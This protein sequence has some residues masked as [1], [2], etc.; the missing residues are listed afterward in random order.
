MQSSSRLKSAFSSL[1]GTSR[2]LLLIAIV[3]ATVFL[4]QLGSARLWD[5]DEPRNAGC[6]AEMLARNDWVT[7]MFNDELR[8]Q[9]PVL[10]YWVMIGAYQLFGVNEFSARI[11]SALM[12]IGTVVLT[13]FMGTQ[14]LGRRQ[15][16]WAAVVLATTLMFTV[17]SRAATPDAPLIFFSTLAI[18]LYVRFTFA[19]VDPV[20]GG[21]PLRQPGIWFPRGIHALLVY[22]TMALGVLAK[23]P[24][25]AVLPCCIIGLFIMVQTAPNTGPD[26]TLWQRVLMLVDPRLFLKSLWRMQ[27]WYLVGAICL[28]AAP[29]F[30]WA[31]YRTDGDF[32]TWFFLEEHFGRATTAMEN[33]SG[34]PWYYPLAILV[35]FFPWSV[36]AIPVGLGVSRFLRSDQHRPFRIGLTLALIWLGLQV[37]VFTLVRTKLPSYVTPCYPAIALMVGTMLAHLESRRVF[38][39]GWWIQGGFVALILVGSALLVG[40]PVAIGELQLQ[41]AW[42]GMI[43]LVPLLTGL[44][45]SWQF[46]KQRLHRIPTTLALG[47]WGFVML[48]FSVGTTVID[49]NRQTGI[50]WQH[51][52]RHQTADSRL[53]T[54]R[55][56]E[57]SW[58]Y[59]AAQPIWEL[60]QMPTTLGTVSQEAD[61]YAVRQAAFHDSL[62]TNPNNPVQ[63]KS[64]HDPLERERPWHSKPR[65]TPQQLIAAYP[66]SY[67]V[68][69]AEYRDELLSQLPAEFREV[70]RCRRF[71]KKG[72]L[73]LLGRD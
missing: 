8:G 10:L 13:Y 40:L 64:L 4:T 15:G 9:K 32:L 26:V 11:G 37:T 16:F 68:V 62:P 21:A 14:L 56:L 41:G 20:H 69:P 72:E 66:N 46:R 57:S 73:V 44:V 35:G 42:L 54:Y 48:F 29:W 52:Q 33:H 6:A 2:D 12:G 17:A 27:P 55:C 60:S 36:L 61:R 5:R 53:A 25:A 47:G 71:L 67:I 22:G 51:V 58:V 38:C 31:G 7:P 18:A 30:V 65:P 23:G 59:Y 70:A 49:S 43:G 45:T 24:I 19:Q 63:P 28:I 50:F 1:P 34:G 39:S 3:A